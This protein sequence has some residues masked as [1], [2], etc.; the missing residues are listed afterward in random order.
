MVSVYLVFLKAGIFRPFLKDRLLSRLL[1]FIVMRATQRE[2]LK[3][4][5]LT[6]RMFLRD[7]YLDS[8]RSKSNVRKSNSIELN[9]WI[10]FD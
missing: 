5:Q 8:R 3:E 7:D 9:P 1:T 4:Q 2:G 6:V 10:E